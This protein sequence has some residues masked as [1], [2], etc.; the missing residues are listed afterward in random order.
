ML[1]EENLYMLINCGSGHFFTTNAVTMF[2]F[3]VAELAL[4]FKAETN[5]PTPAL[6]IKMRC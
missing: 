3:L 2:Q 4:T 1:I 5:K 6:D